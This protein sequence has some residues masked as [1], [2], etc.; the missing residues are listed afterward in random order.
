ML[1]VMV[2]AMAM[3]IIPLSLTSLL[4]LSSC[5]PALSSSSVLKQ[6]YHRHHHCHHHIAPKFWCTL[7]ISIA[8]T[9]TISSVSSASSITVNTHHLDQID[10]PHWR[11]HNPRA[12]FPICS[13]HSA[14]R[15]CLSTARCLL[16]CHVLLPCEE[17]SSHRGFSWK[18]IAMSELK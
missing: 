11:E 1:T 3:R 9:V 17:V 6:G 2:M 16:L 12:A 5:A 14:L 10:R 8:T 7:T 4:P 18:I 13:S 15:H